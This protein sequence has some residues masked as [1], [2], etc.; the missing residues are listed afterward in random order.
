VNVHVTE[1]SGRTAELGGAGRLATKKYT[2]Y[3]NLEIH[4]VNER[5]KGYNFKEKQRFGS[6]IPPAGAARTDSVS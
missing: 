3:R 1:T 2:A 6:L 5:Q 4:F